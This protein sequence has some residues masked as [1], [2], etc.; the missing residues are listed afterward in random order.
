MI[1]YTIMNPLSDQLLKYA[2]VVWHSSLMAAILNTPRHRTVSPVIYSRVA[3]PL[4][5]GYS[6]WNFVAIVYR[7]WDTFNFVSSA[8]MLDFWLQVSSGNL[9]DVTIEKFTPENIGIDTGIL[10][11]SRRIAEL[12]GMATLPPPR[13]ALPN[14]VRCSRVKVYSS[15][16]VDSHNRWMKLGLFYFIHF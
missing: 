2:C 12:P 10:L 13:F 14:S 16:T 6:C 11:R 7:S 9:P 15:W 1:C 3:W 8:A 5:H 4:N